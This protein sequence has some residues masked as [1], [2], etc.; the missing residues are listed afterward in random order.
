MLVQ[1]LHKAVTEGMQ[2]RKPPT[3]GLSDREQ[4]IIRFAVRRFLVDAMNHRYAAAQDV[5]NRDYKPGDMEKFDKD[6]KDAET[7]LAKLNSTT[8]IKE[9]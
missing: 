3:D 9:Q 5:S 2:R 8:N 7:L 4:S 1:D 6:A